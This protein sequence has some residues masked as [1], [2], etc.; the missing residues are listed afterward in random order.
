MRIIVGVR[1]WL[2]CA[3][4][5]LLCVFKSQLSK[6]SVNSLRVSDASPRNVSPTFPI[7]CYALECGAC[8]DPLITCQAVE[9][10]HVVTAREEDGRLGGGLQLEAWVSPGKGNVFMFIHCTSR[11]AFISERD[12]L[13]LDVPKATLSWQVSWPLPSGLAV[14]AFPLVQVHRRLLLVRTALAEKR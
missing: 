1:G 7:K 4:W 14:C 5:Q 10:W 12:V 9:Q 2:L 11:P 6:W 3:G 13:V 8:S